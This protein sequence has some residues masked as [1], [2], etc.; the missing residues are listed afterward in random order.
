MLHLHS[1]PARRPT[2]YPRG[3]V[4]P[5]TLPPGPPGP[6]LLQSTRLIRDPLGFLERCIKRYGDVFTIRFVGMGNLVYIADAAI[7]K[8]IFTGDPTLFHAGEANRIMEPVLGPRSLLLLD[9]DEHLEQRRLLLGPFTA[10]R[11][12]ATPTSSARSSRVRSRAGRSGV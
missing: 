5:M 1:R 2:L 8:D 11:F 3:K 4:R 9:E 10:T 6:A 12:G 7:L